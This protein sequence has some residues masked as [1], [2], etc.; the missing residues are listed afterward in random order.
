MKNIW[1][2]QIYNKK[3]II[4]VSLILIIGIIYAVTISFSLPSNQSDLACVEM[5]IGD[6]YRK[7][8]EIINT[9]ELNDT[10]GMEQYPLNYTIEN[11]C[12]EEKEYEI[13][14]V[15]G[16]NTNISASNIKFAHNN[17]IYTLG[18]FTIVDDGSGEEIYK[19]KT[20]KI[21][22]SE[23]NEYAFRMWIDDSSGVNGINNTLSANVQ[24]AATTKVVIP[25]IEGDYDTVA[26]M[27]VDTTLVAGDVKETRGYYAVGD[28]GKAT[29]N[30]VD[31]GSL[32]ANDMD[33]I[34][35]DNGL[36]AQL[37]Y[38]TEVNVMQFGAHEIENIDTYDTSLDVDSAAV[39][40]RIFDLGI[41]TVNFPFDK[42][43][44]LRDLIFIR[45][46]NITVNGNGSELYTD[47]TYNMGITKE[48]RF[49]TIHGADN[50]VWDN[51]DL[52]ATQTKAIP[53]TGVQFAVLYS[54]NIVIK[55][56]VFRG[57]GP[58]LTKG[59][60]GDFASLEG[61][62]EPDKTTDRFHF[63]NIDLYTGWNNVTIEN[64]ELYLSHDGDYLD[65]A[66]IQLRDIWGGGASGAV[67]RNNYA[68]KVCHDEIL[69]LTTTG[70]D[71]TNTLIEGNTF[72]MYDG[73]HSRSPITI[74]FGYAAEGTSNKFVDLTVQ[75]NIFDIES[76]YIGLRYDNVKGDFTFTRN[77][78]NYK[79][80]SVSSKQSHVLFFDENIE[81]DNF[82]FTENT[83]NITADDGYVI[84]AIAYS[85]APQNVNIDNNEFEI[86]APVVNQMFEGG[87][88]VVNNTI[89][90][91]FMA[92]EIT[93]NVNGFSG[94]DVTL[95]YANS[96]NSHF[97]GTISGTYNYNNNNITMTDVQDK[98]VVDT[99]YVLLEIG[100]SGTV[101]D[102]TTPP[103]INY[104]NNTVTLNDNSLRTGDYKIQ[105]YGPTN[106]SPFVI[107]YNNNTVP[108][109]FWITS[110]AVSSFVV[111]E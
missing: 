13:Q 93:R 89:Y 40:N 45:K 8:L 34:A 19:F 92:Q 82:N 46:P 78:I 102:S 26:D 101:I 111:T 53:N 85:E 66:A 15:L 12:V 35:L 99:P 69:S 105:Y 24:I 33:I 67:V 11:K 17:E 96:I 62:I 49:V 59:D 109:S 29:Y 6:D 94:N 23:K 9:G 65:G 83:F 110:S 44:L 87:M 41:N 79:K 76:N 57:P 36:I 5:S 18:D 48:A 30:I 74:V 38:T 39:L 88:N 100:G 80:V 86:N 90:G 43:F 10:E 21:A 64:N 2:Q 107:N 61:H 4:A 60:D 73:I 3:A 27:K 106:P 22:V 68:E 54:D 32:V 50:I 63:S 55:N 77:T 51:L 37:Q 14:I 16:S 98:S 28:E 84:N 31:A 97:Y 1:L 52:I 104:N 70:K 7:R 42:D 91:N 108:G 72:V 75:D 95:K 47:D 81:T 56:S 58:K 103:I 25:E 71:I 20:E